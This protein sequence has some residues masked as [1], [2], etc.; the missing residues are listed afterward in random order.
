[1]LLEQQARD[2]E[3]GEDEEHVYADVAAREKIGVVAEHDQRDRY[4]SK[5][6]ERRHIP[7]SVPR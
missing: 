2:E 4:A 5:S 6:I 7:E 3:A 1:M